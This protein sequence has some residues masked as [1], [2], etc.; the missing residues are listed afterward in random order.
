[1]DYNKLALKCMKK[2]RKSKYEIV[3]GNKRQR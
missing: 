2:S 3:G 1:M